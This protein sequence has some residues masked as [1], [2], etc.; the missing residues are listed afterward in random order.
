MYVRAG[1]PASSPARDTCEECHW[2]SQFFGSVLKKVPHYAPDEKN[3]LNTYEILVKV[4]GL[5]NHLGQAEGIHMHMLDGVEYVAEDRVLEEIPWV[6]Y[7][8]TDGKPGTDPPPAGGPHEGMLCS[9]CHDGGLEALG[10]RVGDTSGSHAAT[11][12]PAGAG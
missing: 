1:A 3:T 6:R 9:D 12:T 7:K 2:P 8:D 11:A 4:G 5:N 10:W